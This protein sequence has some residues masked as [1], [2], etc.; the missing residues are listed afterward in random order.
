[1][2][3]FPDMLKT[4][5]LVLRC[6]RSE[7]AL[8]ILH[9]AQQNRDQLIREF[10]QIAGLQNLEAAL[11]FSAEKREQSHAA[12]NF[13]YGIWRK[14]RN[15]QIGQIQVKNIAWEIPSAELSYFISRSMQ[16]QGYASDSVK[17]IPCLAFQ[18]LKVQRVFVRILPSNYESFYF[19]KKL[20]FQGEGLLRS[21]FR[22]GFGELHDV[23]YLSLTIEDY[24]R[25]NPRR[26]EV[27]D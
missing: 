11:F 4:E 3:S 23:H 9:F 15:E 16:R 24:C 25:H 2:S 13:C 19:A 20:G 10:P 6:Y 21:A 27:G 7:D 1:M 18:E 5:R 17:R 26:N 14:H 22:C 8:C 12:K